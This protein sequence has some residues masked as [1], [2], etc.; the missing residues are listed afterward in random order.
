MGKTITV[1]FDYSDDNNMSYI[2]AKKAIECG[3]SVVTCCTS[4]L[5]F[6]YVRWGYH[7]K[8]VKKD[9]SYIDLNKMMCDSSK[10][11]NREIRMSHNCEKMLISG[12][13]KWA[14]GD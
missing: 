8:V 14:S 6:M 5:A 9:G 12:S 2:E 7:V 11:I 4:F 1:T 10:Y 3:E 13:L